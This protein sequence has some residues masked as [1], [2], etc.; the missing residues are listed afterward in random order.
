LYTVT[1]TYLPEERHLFL[2]RLEKLETDSTLRF[3]KKVRYAKMKDRSRGS[4]CLP[5]YE[6]DIFRQFCATS[7][8]AA[9]GRSVA[10]SAPKL[11]DLVNS[12]DGIVWEADAQTFAFSFVIRKPSACWAIR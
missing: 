12:L 7:A 6:A 5:R 8:N 1:D 10:R 4:L 9:R 11:C 3:E 2:E